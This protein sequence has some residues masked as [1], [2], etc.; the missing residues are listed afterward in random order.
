MTT[1]FW[2][3]K[4]VFVTG[5]TGF[6]GSWLCLMLDALGA[7]VHGY[8]LPAPSDPSMFDHLN[9]GSMIERST[10]ANVNDPETLRLALMEAKPDVII[11]MA[12]QS[13]VGTSYSD[14]TETFA[15]NVMGTVNLLEAAR[16]LNH[17]CAIVN[18]TTD[19][20]YENKEWH[21]P[22]R[23][24]EPLGG[25]DPYSA[26]K[27]CSELVTAAY[28][29]SFFEDTDIFLASARA[30][31][32]IGGGDWSE[33]RLIPDVMRAFQCQ[34][35][36]EI[37]HPKATR[38][39]Q[40]VAEP[41]TG[42][43][44]LAEALYVKG[45]AFAGAWNFG[46]RDDG[47]QTVEQVLSLIEKHFATPLPVTLQDKSFHEATLLKLDCNKA[48]HVLGWQPTL[49]L[50]EAVEWTSSWYRAFFDQDDMLVFS[51]KQIARFLNHG[52]A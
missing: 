1:G 11:H 9:V 51:K 24:N 12:A 29:Q 20:C 6:K 52:G 18:V 48:M 38:P 7:R 41:L 44:Q 25:H 47:V 13:L 37:R 8:S 3:D 2:R 5:H 50:E 26:S 42:Y 31:N 46:P 34:S 36:L 21:W 33:R 19:K 10:M 40:F 49:C 14:P 28:R 15:T 4:S 27:A 32:V 17:K 45:K 35:P 30:G 23:E 22:Y 39:W 16:C 43:L